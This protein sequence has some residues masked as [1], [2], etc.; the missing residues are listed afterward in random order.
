[1]GSP[2]LQNYSKG[3][4]TAS[5]TVSGSNSV[6]ELPALTNVTY[7]AYN[8]PLN[9]QALA[10]GHLLATNL[11]SLAGYVDVLADGAGS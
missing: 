3:A 4:I 7:T 2:A 5:W 8:Y 6:L 10:G 1:M 11:V 9:I